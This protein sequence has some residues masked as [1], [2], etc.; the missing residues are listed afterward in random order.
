MLNVR[1]GSEVAEG[2]TEDRAA[3]IHTGA[4]DVA[5]AGPVPALEGSVRKSGE[6]LRVT[7]QLIRGR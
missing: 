7:A 6:T 5:G 2:D 4:P 1:G 3:G